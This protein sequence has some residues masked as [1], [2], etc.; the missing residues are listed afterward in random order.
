VIP[1]A[2]Q[3]PSTTR[4]RPTLSPR[5]PIGLLAGSGRFPI[6]F[7]EAAKRQGLP[8]ACVGIRYEA[9]DELAAICDS[10]DVAGVSKMGRVIRTF[11]RRGVRHI[12]MAGKITKSVMYTPWRIFQLWPDWRM[13]HYFYWTCRRDRTDDSLLLGVIHEFEG[14]GLRFGSAL[15]YC[16]ELLVKRGVLTRRRLSAAESKDVA[17]GWKMAKAMGG[18]DVGQSVAVKDLSTIAIEAIEGT[19]RCIDRAGSLCRAGG[20]T[21]VKVAKPQQDMRFDVPTVGTDTIESLHRAGARV[22][23]IEADRTIILD[24]PDVV[25]LADRYGISIVAVDPAEVVGA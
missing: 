12:V 15:D 21:L 3:R 4:V 6:L 7:A 19:D 24:E 17:F 2:L 8:V 20:W 5:E 18:L 9:S 13:I 10:F 16:P 25:A 1:S 11:K 22:L 14:F 23:G